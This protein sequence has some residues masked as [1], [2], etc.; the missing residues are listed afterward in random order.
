MISMSEDEW[1]QDNWVQEDWD[2]EKPESRKVAENL[3]Q[4]LQQ[5]IE[6]EKPDTIAEVI[7]VEIPAKK[8]VPVEI[9]QIKLSRNDLILQGV[10][11]GLDMFGN[12]VKQVFYMEMESSKQIKRAQILDN[13]E[14]FHNM[15]EQF[16][17]PGASLIERSIG[18]AILCLFN[19]PPAAGLSFA[20]ALEIIKRHPNPD[21]SP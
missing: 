7:K 3:E 6:S 10:D 21:L 4:K 8:E 14:E 12:N 2:I 16:F 17:G 15:I 5:V 13:R 18:R 20:T 1:S 9:K 19:L 11:N